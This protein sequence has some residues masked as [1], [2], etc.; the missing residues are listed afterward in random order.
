MLSLGLVCCLTGTWPK[1]GVWNFY[2]RQ[3]CA[4]SYVLMH[5]GAVLGFSTPGHSYLSP[6]DHL[7][8]LSSK[9]SP[10]CSK[11]STSAALCSSFCLCP[12]RFH[13]LT[14]PR[15][16]CHPML[17]APVCTNSPHWLPNVQGC[18]YLNLK[19]NHFPFKCL[20]PHFCQAL[21]VLG[22]MGT[23]RGGETSGMLALTNSSLPGGWTQYSLPNFL[24]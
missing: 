19:P 24:S 21:Q 4:M 20:H 5:S 6:L 12:P 9:F 23:R 17:M 13:L 16:L 1:N 22:G 11:V 18:L 3:F 10:P 15:S 14:W 8:F 2:Y 7:L